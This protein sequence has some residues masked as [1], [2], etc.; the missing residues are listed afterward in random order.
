MKPKKPVEYK[1]IVAWG[2]MMQSFSYYING[3]VAKAIKDNAPKTA[4]YRQDDGTWATWEDIK[5]PD[6]RSTIE[7]IANSL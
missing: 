7:Q 4:I 3:E 5:S 6:T 2:R 1:Y